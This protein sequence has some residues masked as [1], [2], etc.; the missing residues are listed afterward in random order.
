MRHWGLSAALSSYHSSVSRGESRAQLLERSFRKRL[1][2]GAVAKEE[3]EEGGPAGR[4]GTIPLFAL[5]PSS[6]SV[7]Y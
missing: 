5:F 6:D 1:L 2:T 7:G 3:E 4:G